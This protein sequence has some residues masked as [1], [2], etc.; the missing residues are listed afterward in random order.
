MCH[1]MGKYRK[2]VNKPYTEKW[3][4]LS[5]VLKEISQ[6]HG[7]GDKADWQGEENVG[8]KNE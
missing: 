4:G 8:W 5:R 2:H 6:L 7:D 3:R 1:K